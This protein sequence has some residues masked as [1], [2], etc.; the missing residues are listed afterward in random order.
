MPQEQERAEWQCT[1]RGLTADKDSETKAPEAKERNGQRKC[2]ERAV[3]AG[4]EAPE[5]KGTGRRGQEQDVGGED[6]AQE[7]SAQ[8][9]GKGKGKGKGSK[10]GRSVGTRKGWVDGSEGKSVGKEDG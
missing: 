9:K 6:K 1:E 7:G 5:T 10:V 4:E 2:P 8:K 3:G